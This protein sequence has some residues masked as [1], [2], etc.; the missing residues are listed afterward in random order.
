MA[1]LGKLRG[2][3][4]KARA[5]LRA[6]LQLRRCTEVGPLT[7]V[8]GR[9]TVHNGG[10]ITLGRKVRLYG[11][12]VPVELAALPGAEVSIGDRT[13]INAGT[14]ICAH[15]S[16]R[17]GANCGIGNY[18]LIM[19]TDFHIVG[20]YEQVRVPEPSPV[21]IGDNVWIAARSVVMKGV[22]IGD[23]AVVCAGSVVVTN[24]APNTMVGGSPAR[25]IKKLDPPNGL[26]PAGGAEAAPAPAAAAAEA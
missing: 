12:Q 10:R 7:Q 15:R 1:M 14:S 9:V 21:V 16:V 11:E 23:G 13:A 20:D 18:T 24:V 25:L 19:D 4:G 2:D 17:I 22:T 6:R 3:L 26:V 5:A 8:R